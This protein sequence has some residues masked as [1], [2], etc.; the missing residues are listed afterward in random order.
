MDEI[1][2]ITIYW[3]LK[4]SCKP[5]FFMNEQEKEIECRKVVE[6]ISKDLKLW[7]FLKRKAEKMT[8]EDELKYLD[9][10]LKLKESKI[11]SVEKAIFL[12]VKDANYLI[13]L[14]E[15]ENMDIPLLTKFG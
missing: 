5:L 3:H 12:G 9:L 4:Y 2:K 11:S 13:R 10:K 6:T 8:S 1:L 7:E 14:Q 15:R